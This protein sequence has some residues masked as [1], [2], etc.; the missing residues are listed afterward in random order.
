MK[1]EGRDEAGMAEETYAGSNITRS[2][3]R[4]LGNSIT[5]LGSVE[6]HREFDWTGGQGD[7]ND[8]LMI[9]WVRHGVGSNWGVPVLGNTY[10]RRYI[11]D[12]YR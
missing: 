3:K 7:C 9:P 8:D 1:G 5:N 11:F 6:V 10:V 12:W 4:S 2:L